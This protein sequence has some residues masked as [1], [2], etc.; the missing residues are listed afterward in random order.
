M[1]RCYKQTGINV[2]TNP[3][4]KIYFQGRIIPSPTPKNKQYFQKQTMRLPIFRNIIWRGRSPYHLP[5]QTQNSARELKQ[6]TSRRCWR[7]ARRLPNVEFPIPFEECVARFVEAE[8]EAEAAYMLREHSAEMLRAA[9][10]WTPSTGF[11]RCVPHQCSLYIL[12]EVLFPSTQ[13]RV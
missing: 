8:A 10:G 13:R 6:F 3:P 5:L 2:V 4:M 7:G 9:S 11:G 12:F 1:T